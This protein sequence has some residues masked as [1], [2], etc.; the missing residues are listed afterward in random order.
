MHVWHVR[1]V[2]ALVLQQ[3]LM[4]NIGE[5]EDEPPPTEPQLSEDGRFV[6]LPPE[7]SLATVAPDE[8]TAEDC[9]SE[10]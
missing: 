3:I 7:Q 4:D 1:P 8:A 2:N 10:A 6:I 5:L 9:E